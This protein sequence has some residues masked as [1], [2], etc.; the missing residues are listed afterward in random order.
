MLDNK[1]IALLDD[2]LDDNLSSEETEKVLSEVESNPELKELLGILALTRDSIRMSGHRET[3][4]EIQREFE[5]KESNLDS[6]SKVVKFK[7]L[8]WWIGIAASLSILL[9]VGN[10]WVQNLPDNLYQDK[11]MAY[12]IPTM[13]SA[14]QADD[15]L[16]DD[17]KNKIW[18]SVTKSVNLEDQN[19]KNLFLAGLSYFELKDYS[20]AQQY[21]SKIKEINDSETGKLFEDEIDYYLFLIHL[22]SEKYQDARLLMNKISSDTNHTYHDSFDFGDRIK[23]GALGIFESKSKISK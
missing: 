2:Y 1:Y 12:E 7:P 6:I 8:G 13:R 20:N 21:L 15:K 23:L 16:Q 3:I 4:K 14:G 10:Y 9:L 19:R 17:F 5:K 11:Y 22:R 18:D